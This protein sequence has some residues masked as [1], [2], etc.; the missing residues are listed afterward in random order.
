MLPPKYLANL[1]P[2]QR[3]LQQRLIKQSQKEYERT[4]KVKDR[5]KVSSRKTPRSS[6]AAEFQERFG[7]PVTNLK[8][9]RATFPDTDVSAILG[10]GAAAYASSGSRPNV[11]SFQWRMARLASVLTGG[12]AYQIDKDLVGN[13]SKNKIF[14]K[15]E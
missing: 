4:G 9:V 6:H 2:Q 1:T 13:Q 7:F 8:R 5:P 12:K 3:L 10:K 14:G 11:S 15:E